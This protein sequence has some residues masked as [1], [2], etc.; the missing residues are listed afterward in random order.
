MRY[1]PLSTSRDIPPRSAGHVAGAE[2][3]ARQAGFASGEA[4]RREADGQ[5][6]RGD[7]PGSGRGRARRPPGPVARVK[8]ISGGPSGCHNADCTPLP[9]ARTARYR[10]A[11]VNGPLRRA[12]CDY[13][14][15]ARAP[16]GAGA[17]LRIPAHGSPRLARAPGH[18]GRRMQNLDGPCSRTARKATRPGWRRQLQST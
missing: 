11:R 10:Y 9:R 8:G 6:R 16:A 14:K 15:S 17:F 13:D 12:I 1:R 2:G 3:Y 7:L 4:G 18:F 5:G